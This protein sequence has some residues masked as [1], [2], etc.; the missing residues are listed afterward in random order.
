MKLL[1]KV[2]PNTME[3]RDVTGAELAFSARL[4]KDIEILAQN[5][6]Q[7]RVI[8]ILAEAIQQ[9]LTT[10]PSCR[11][12]QRVPHYWPIENMMRAIIM[13]LG[14]DGAINPGYY[15]SNNL[16]FVRELARELELEIPSFAK[17]EA[18]RKVRLASLD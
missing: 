11:G 18:G 4:R 15:I 12:G 2:S 1:R 14:R 17:A 8:V 16:R 13:I 9:E 3:K 6:R 10:D 7:R 5:G